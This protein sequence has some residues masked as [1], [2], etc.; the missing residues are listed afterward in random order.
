MD[1][2]VHIFLLCPQNLL[3]PP[4]NL[5]WDSIIFWDSTYPISKKNIRSV[6]LD[7]HFI[8]PVSF[9]FSLSF[10]AFFCW[11]LMDMGF[12]YYS[13]HIYT[14]SSPWSLPD[15]YKQDLNIFYNIKVNAYYTVSIGSNIFFQT[16]FCGHKLCQPLCKIS[17]RNNKID[18]RSSI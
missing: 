2:R 17:E 6:I 4:Q 16:Y 18:F 12:I 3:D 1:A 8:I 14:T 5:Y 9:F 11:S 13:Q 7:K 10:W 15:T